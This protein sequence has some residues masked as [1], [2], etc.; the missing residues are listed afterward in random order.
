[1]QVDRRLLFIEPDPISQMAQPAPPPRRRFWVRCWHKGASAAAGA[2]NGPPPPSWVATIWGAL[3]AIPGRQPIVDNLVDLAQRNETVARIRDII[4]T[5]FDEVAERVKAFM[6]RQLSSPDPDH[7]LESVTPEHIRTWRQAIEQDAF[8]FAAFNAA[9]YLRT[10]LRLLLDAYAQLVTRF[11]NFQP[12]SYQ[13]VFL[14]SVFRHWAGADRKNVGDAAGTLFERSAQP[15][16]LQQ[17]FL[18]RFDLGYHDR[19]IRFVIAALSWWYRE[20]GHAGYPSRMELDRAKHRLYHHLAELQQVLQVAVETSDIASGLTALFKQRS[21]D[22]VARGQ[23]MQA[24]VHRYQAQLDTLRDELGAHLEHVLPQLEDN[25]YSDFVD[26]CGAWPSTVRFALLVRY[27]GFPYWDMLVYPVQALSGVGERDHV[28]VLR[29]SPLDATQLKPEN[30]A[31][32]G[33]LKGV[34]LKHFSAFFRR[35]YRENDY[36]WGRLDAA[37]RLIALL[38]D[39][40]GQPGLSIADPQDCRKAF[41]AILDAE[42]QSLRTIPDLLRHLRQQVE[43]E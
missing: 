42:E 11:L 30:P 1:V 38:L 24:F 18:R 6:D 15:T 4:E 14:L 25:L 37:E 8:Q 43:A 40:P 19:R 28:E 39:D 35:D 20:N 31:Q 17:A 36:L 34:S 32:E 22:A 5:S 10:R 27:L 2:P 3:S 26:M 12:Q 16:S 7:L 23:A 21:F 13:A 9:T 41:R 29:I 33:K